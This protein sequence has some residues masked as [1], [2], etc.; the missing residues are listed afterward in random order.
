MTFAFNRSAASGPEN[1]EE[2][3]EGDKRARFAYPQLFAQHLP[4]H[5]TRRGRETAPL[6]ESRTPV[7]RSQTRHLLR[8]TA[9]DRRLE[10]LSIPRV[11][12]RRDV[13]TCRKNLANR[14]MEAHA[15][16]SFE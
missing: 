6:Q 2:M 8:S 4:A 12:R 9:H 3:I 13:L 7:S 14:A 10:Q 1:M 5:P 15:K 16:A 11:G